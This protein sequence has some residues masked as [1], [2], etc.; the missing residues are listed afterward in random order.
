M[1]QDDLISVH[2]KL[3]ICSDF[4]TTPFPSFTENDLEKKKYII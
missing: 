1:I 2:Q 4:H 3:K